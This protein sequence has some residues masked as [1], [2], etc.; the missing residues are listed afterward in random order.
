ML[1]NLTA[2]PEERI[3][4]SGSKPRAVRTLMARLEK[5]KSGMLPAN[6]LPEDKAGNP[7]NFGGV[8]QTGWCT[9]I[10]GTSKNLQGIPQVVWLLGIILL[11]A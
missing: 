2:D 5:L 1:F 4:L 10:S 8:W 9:A 3:N 11:A 6:A 7:A